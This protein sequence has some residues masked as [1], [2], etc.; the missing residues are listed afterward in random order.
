MAFH[1]DNGNPVALPFSTGS[2]NTLSGSVPAQGSAY[3]EAGNPQA[4][5]VSGSAQITADPSIVVQALF[6]DDSSGRYYEAAVPSSS[7]SQEFLFPFDATTFAGNGQPF[8]TG[9]AI[10]NL[11]GSPAD[12]ICTARDQNGVVIPN[13]VPVP[14]LSSFGHWANYLFPALTGMRGTVDCVSSTTVAATALRFIGGSAFSSL[15]VITK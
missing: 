3:Y 6:R 7:G 1:D 13:A 5:L 15:P 10:A 4:S 11:S 9:F 2:T 14:E 8:Y 12:L